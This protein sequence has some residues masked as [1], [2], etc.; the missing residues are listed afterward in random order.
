M[1]IVKDRDRIRAAAERAIAA[2]QAIQSRPVERSSS[3]RRPCV[4]R[5]GRTDGTCRTSGRGSM[6][7]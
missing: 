7:R 2:M 3:S 5:P 1:T 4:S 6:R